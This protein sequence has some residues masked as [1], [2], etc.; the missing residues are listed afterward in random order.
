[1]YV[2]AIESIEIQTNVPIS[3]KFGTV[4]G[5]DPGMVMYL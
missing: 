2:S 3:M 1:M 5:H 4:E